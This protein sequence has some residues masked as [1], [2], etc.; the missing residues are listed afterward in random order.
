MWFALFSR[1]GA[2]LSNLIRR[3]LSSIRGKFVRRSGA[4]YPHD[5]PL[6][7][8]PVSRCRARHFCRVD[9]TSHPVVTLFSIGKQQAVIADYSFIFSWL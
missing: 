9:H 2:F 8:G 3:F 6:G 4:V 5:N 7:Q 1:F